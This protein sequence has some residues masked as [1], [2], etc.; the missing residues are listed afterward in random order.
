MET[1]QEFP[2]ISCQSLLLIS[3]TLITLFIHI[4]ENYHNLKM[5]TIAI[6]FSALSILGLIYFLAIRSITDNNTLWLISIISSLA[7]ITIIKILT[8]YVARLQISFKTSSDP[9]V[10]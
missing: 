1:T 7:S 4:L 10:E 5:R 3:I 8:N 6:S 2:Y 9:A